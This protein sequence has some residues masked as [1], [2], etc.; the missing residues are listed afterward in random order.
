MESNS[1]ANRIHCSS[2]AAELLSKQAPELPLRSR[3]LIPIKGKGHIHTYWVNEGSKSGVLDKKDTEN[4]I[5]WVPKAK[6]RSSGRK[7]PSLLGMN[8]PNFLLRPLDRLK[9]RDK[10]KDNRSSEFS[11]IRD[12][13]HSNHSRSVSLHSVDLAKV[14]EQFGSS[15]ESSG[16]ISFRGSANAGR[17]SRANSRG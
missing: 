4:M 10:N 15:D 9:D 3:G 11:L 16:E 17:R 2:A 12:S 6:R 8:A 5:G 14:V 1:K 7:R 13:N